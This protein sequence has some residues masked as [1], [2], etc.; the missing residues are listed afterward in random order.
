MNATQQNML[1][2]LLL[3][4]VAGVF[5]IIVGVL[6]SQSLRDEGFRRVVKRWLGR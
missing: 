6:S 1:V 3:V 4:G 5:A 2:L